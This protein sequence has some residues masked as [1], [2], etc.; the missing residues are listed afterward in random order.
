MT[1]PDANC[2][3]VEQS[4]RRGS[5]PRTHPRCLAFLSLLAILSLLMS[6]LVIPNCP[7]RTDLLTGL[8]FRLRSDRRPAHSHLQRFHDLTVVLWPYQ[9][10][11]GMGHLRGG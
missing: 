10:A 7:P 1:E 3:S 2:N 8:N 4:S 6:S 9:C 5:L 11:S